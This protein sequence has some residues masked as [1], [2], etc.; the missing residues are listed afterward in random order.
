MAGVAR[1]GHGEPATAAINASA[2]KRAPRRRMSPVALLVAT[3]ITG[4]LLALSGWGIFSVAQAAQVA[5]GPS[6]AANTQAGGQAEAGG[7]SQE[8][9]LARPGGERRLARSPRPVLARSRAVGLTR[10]S[11]PAG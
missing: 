9:G 5:A 7:S 1:R 4:G 10:R 11:P 6:G 2:H 3:L 8:A